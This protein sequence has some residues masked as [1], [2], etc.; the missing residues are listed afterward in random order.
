M[1]RNQHILHIK[2]TQDHEWTWI[3]KDTNGKVVSGAL[4]TFHNREDACHGA[5]QGSPVTAVHGE[6]SSITL[7]SNEERRFISGKLVI[8]DEQEEGEE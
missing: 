7:Y 4:D 8:D 1:S 3:F 6:T 5:I 2:R